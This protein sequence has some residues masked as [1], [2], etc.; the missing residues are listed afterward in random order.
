M[1][2]VVEKLVDDQ[3][4]CDDSSDDDSSNVFEYG[5]EGVLHSVLEVEDMDISESC[6]DEERTVTMIEDIVETDETVVNNSQHAHSPEDCAQE[7]NNLSPLMQSK[8]VEDNT[9]VIIK[10]MKTALDKLTSLD[11]LEE[12]VSLQSR[13]RYLVSQEKLVELV[14][15]TC[16]EQTD[17]QKCDAQLSFHS[18]VVGSSLELT[19]YCK[20]G[21]GRKWVSSETLPSKKRGTIAINDGLLASAVIIS[22]NNYSK[23]S[24][25]CQALGMQIISEASFLRFQK[26]CA[27]P[28]IEEVWLEMNELVKQIFKDY[29]EICLCG[30]GRNDSP[31]HSARYCVYTLVEHFTS[32]VVDFSVID[33]RETGGNSTTMEKE[34]LRRL[35]EKLAVG[36]PFQ[37]LTTD[38]SPAV[39]KLGRELK[40]KQNKS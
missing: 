40:G 21:H 18:K 20:S 26:H 38:A 28:V 2:S 4:E 32:A 29:E 33:K 23:F 39:I 12:F 6:L 19:W 35:L 17:G 7:P 15:S 10:T 9:E 8:K 13:S 36:F 22:G 14:G 1:A 5:N 27:A 24:L 31:G 11:G 34:A 3:S 16:C 30:D 37:E 25:L